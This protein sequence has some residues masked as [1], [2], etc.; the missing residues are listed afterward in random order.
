VHRTDSIGSRRKEFFQKT[1]FFSYPHCVRSNCGI[2]YTSVS[3][4]ALKPKLLYTVRT[5]NPHG[6]VNLNHSQNV[7]ITYSKKWSDHTSPRPWSCQEMIW[8][9]L[10]TVFSD[11]RTCRKKF[12]NLKYFLSIRILTRSRLGISLCY[13]CHAL[14]KPKGVYCGLEMRVGI[15]SKAIRTPNWLNCGNL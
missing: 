7:P 14:R 9:R 13:L 12:E 10:Q 15:K 3:L 11:W 1:L 2:N 6:P 8:H 5:L 4:P